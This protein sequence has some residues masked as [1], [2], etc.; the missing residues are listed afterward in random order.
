MRLLEESG[1]LARIYDL[2]YRLGVTAHYTG[3]FYTSHALLL[4]LRQPERLL[5]VTKWLYPD[6]AKHYQTTWQAVEHAIRTVVAAA[7]KTNREL[8]CDLA[9]QSLEKKPSPTHFLRILA[10]SLAKEDAA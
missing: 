7:W 8:L 2:L 5:L 4:S 1:E 3:F 9:G 6:V 10:E